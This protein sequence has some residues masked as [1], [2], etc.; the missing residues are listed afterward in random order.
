MD[1]FDRIGNTPMFKIDN[2]KNDIYLIEANR[3]S[4]KDYEI[5]GFLKVLDISFDE[6][7]KDI[8]QKLEK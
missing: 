8:E 2:D 5:W 1:V 4:V 3:R 7:Y 6:L